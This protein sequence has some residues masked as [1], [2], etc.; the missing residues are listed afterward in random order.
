MM[1]NCRVKNLMNSAKMHQN[2]RYIHHLSA[3]HDLTEYPHLTEWLEVIP[4]SLIIV[5]W[6][7][8]P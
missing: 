1:M 5:I 6:M 7:I 2:P 3:C 8:H 4:Q